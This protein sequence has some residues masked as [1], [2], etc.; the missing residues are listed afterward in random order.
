[1]NTESDIAAMRYWTWTGKV[2]PSRSKKTLFVPSEAVRKMAIDVNTLLHI[3]IRKEMAAEDDEVWTWTSGLLTRGSNF[4]L[5]IPPEAVAA[6][7][8]VNDDFLHTE[9]KIRF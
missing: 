7:T 3:T 2:S 5:E 9:I 1:M 8:I 4:V 6:M